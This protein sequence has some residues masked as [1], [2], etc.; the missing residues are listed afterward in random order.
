MRV[1]IL[2]THCVNA[3]SPFPSITT[4]T[5]ERLIDALD[6]WHFEPHKLPDEQILACTQ[7]LFEALLRIEG[8]QIAVGVS[9]SENRFNLYCLMCWSDDQETAQLSSFLL[10]LRQAYRATNSYHNFQHA[11][12]VFQAT[13]MYLR[14]AGAVPP[15]SILHF[16]ESDPRGRWTA[17][18]ELKTTWIGILRKEDIFALYIA[19]VGHDVGHPGFN[20]IFM[21]CGSLQLHFFLQS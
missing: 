7:L 20:N 14:T 13:H 16:P 15:V 2:D 19:A 3:S 1:F 8:M 17:H 11:L 4:A 21:V 12:D 10:H 18:D 9:I 6:S 5:R